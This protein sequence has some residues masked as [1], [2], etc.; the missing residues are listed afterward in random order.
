M[1]M[2]IVQEAE[3]EATCQCGDHL[4]RRV[5][6]EVKKSGKIAGV[7]A[8]DK[9]KKISQPKKVEYSAAEKKTV[10]AMKAKAAGRGAIN[11]E[12]KKRPGEEAR[13]VVLTT[14]PVRTSSCT[15]EEVDAILV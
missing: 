2:H 9:G 10:F 13:L 3:R 15:K 4:P 6:G 12:E 14:M 7:V 8:D 11:V 1:Y 5:E